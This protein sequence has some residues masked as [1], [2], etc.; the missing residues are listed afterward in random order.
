MESVLVLDAQ[1]RNSLAVIRSLGKRR[2]RVV[3]GEETAFA[4]GLFSRYCHGRFIYPSPYGAAERFTTALL[5]HVKSHR[6]SVL[7]PV[8][9]ATVTPVAQHYDLFSQYVRLPIPPLATLQRALDKRETILAAR[10]HGI[11]HPRT[12]LVG[13]DGGLDDAVRAIPFPA[14]IKP[15]RSFGSRGLAIV[16]DEAELRRAYAETAA[17]YGSGLIQEH[18]PS[19]GEIGVSALLNFASEVRAICVHRRIRSYP[20]SGG[21]STLRETIR[22]PDAVALAAE[23]LKKLEWWGVAM[24]EFRVDAR[25]GVPKLMEVNPRFWGSLQ[26][27][28]LAGVDFPYLLHK[29]V[30]T[31]AT[32]TVPD[33]RVGVKCRWL[34]PGDLLHFWASPQKWR[35]LPDFLKFYRRDMGYDTFSLEDPLPSLA[36]LATVLRF[37]MSKKMW[38]FVL[39]DPGKVS[40][41]GREGAGGTARGHCSRGAVSRRVN[42]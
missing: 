40:G 8:T 17:R 5:E 1:A 13:E 29:L 21:P 38:A 33:Y 24:V 30:T 36:L 16:R 32:D 34:V 7:Y 23:F 11:P 19:A 3:G 27:S 31:G 41:A 15:A 6:Y 14:V 37:S 10:R 42:P 20:V 35:L 25:D 12:F 28:I 9:D 2:L 18:I 26:L 4:P 39:R 22:R